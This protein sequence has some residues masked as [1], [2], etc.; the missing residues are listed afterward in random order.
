MEDT[1]I[2]RLSEDRILVL[3]VDSNDS[4]IVKDSIT[5]KISATDIVITSIP[6]EFLN[7]LGTREFDIL[8]INC[9]LSDVGGGMLLR[10]LKLMEHEPTVL[11]VANS[12][13][14]ATVANLYSAGCQC[15]IVKSEAW[16]S[17]LGPAVASLSRQRRTQEAIAR[18]SAQLT[19]IN[20]ILREKNQRL[21]EFSMTVAH[22]I[23]GP[24]GGIGMNIE[25]VIDTYGA[26]I[27]GRVKDLL[28]RALDASQH[29]TDI[30]QAMYSYARI[31]A[32]S[33]TMSEV[34]L[35]ELVQKVASELHFPESLDIRVGIGELP[36]VWGNA[37]LLSRVFFN[38]INNAVKYNDKR[39]IVVNIGTERVADRTL[40]RYADIFVKDNGPGIPESDLKNIFTM[41][42]RSAS[43]ATG[44]EGLGIGLAV[45]QRI[46]GLH[47]GDVSVVS[48]IGE[49]TK[50]LIS[51]PMEESEV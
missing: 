20:R 26:E 4:S 29:L 46:V 21:D 22:D 51:L 37:D 32:K 2:E 1:E 47:Y 44:K 25:Y 11:V 34:D 41:F 18:R 23:R 3:D 33:V 7:L 49:G 9:D 16:L 35:G 48:K 28:R 6:S 5:E 14:P 19:E 38:L 45:V 17:E 13:D 42:T 50:F 40:C 39:E 8:V 15:C 12:S 31:G 27:P 10:E 43:N 30:V 36:K 24:L